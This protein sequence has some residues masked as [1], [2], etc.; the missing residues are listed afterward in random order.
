MESL[1]V[2]GGRRDAAVLLGIGAREDPLQD[3][4][5]AHHLVRNIGI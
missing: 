2:G 3:L 1:E 5:G 4:H